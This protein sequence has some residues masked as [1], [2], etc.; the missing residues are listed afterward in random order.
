MKE[1]PLTQGQVA[2]VSDEDYEDLSQFKWFA[3]YSTFTRSFYA[4]RKVRP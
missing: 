4:K 2:I 3:Y 1:I